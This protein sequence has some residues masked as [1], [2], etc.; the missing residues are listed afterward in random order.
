[1]MGERLTT[2]LEADCG[3][4]VVALLPLGGTDARAAQASWRAGTS[5]SF[6][7]S[8]MAGGATTA[9]S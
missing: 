4:N 7:S 9:Q 2:D 1:M 6:E 3:R 5:A 8:A